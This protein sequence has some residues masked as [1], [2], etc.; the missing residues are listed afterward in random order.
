MANILSSGA[1]SENP[2]G[3][4][5]TASQ[6]VLSTLRSQI[7]QGAMPAGTRLRQNHVAEQLGVSSTPVREALRDLAAEGLVELDVHKGAVVRGLTLTDAAEIYRLRMVLEPLLIEE[8]FGHITEA[9]LQACEHLIEKMAAT[10]NVQDWANWNAQF[11]ANLMDLPVECRLSRMVEQLRE[12]AQPYVY[13]SLYKRSD[14]MLRSDREHR[15]LIDA[16]RSGQIAVVV[17]LTIGHLQATLD[18]IKTS[19][20]NQ[21]VP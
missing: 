12:A 1:P 3:R 8:S 15:T 7:L 17:D 2:A 5:R 16:Y 10:Q 13:L 6:Y 11:H 20:T 9:H 18:L 21:P 19:V 14:E 4:P